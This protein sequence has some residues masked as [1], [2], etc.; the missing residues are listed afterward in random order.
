MKMKQTVKEFVDGLAVLDVEKHGIV[1]AIR[2]KVKNHYS[3]IEERMM[4]GGIMFSLEEDLGGVFVYSKHVSFEFGQGYLFDDPLNLL[5][6][7]GKFRRH[8]KIYS[9]DDK[10]FVNLDF[11]L[12]QMLKE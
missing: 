12:K 1:I 6:G 7:K 8:L 9:K 4:Y 3:M 2:E 10:R 5:E 11:Y